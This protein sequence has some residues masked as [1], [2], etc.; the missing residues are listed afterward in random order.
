MDCKA[1]HKNKSELVLSHCKTKIGK[2][3]QSLKS[4][5]LPG[6]NFVKEVTFY[7]A[8][9]PPYGLGR[10]PISPKVL[11]LA[12]NGEKKQLYHGSPVR[13]RV[14]DSEKEWK[15]YSISANTKVTFNGARF[16]TSSDGGIVVSIDPK[17]AK[18][19]YQKI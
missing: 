2:Q 19:K 18:K 7:A 14:I 3:S 4:L 5:D 15:N 11:I 13:I 10:C 1:D 12:F 6:F 9:S 17:F 8:W 16:N